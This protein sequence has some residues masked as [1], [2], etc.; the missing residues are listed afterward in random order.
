MKEKM[1]II[2]KKIYN[3]LTKFFPNVS[4]VDTALR[5]HLVLNEK[6]ILFLLFILFLLIFNLFLLLFM[7]PL[8]FFVLFMNPTILFQLILVLSTVL[9]TK[10]FQFQLN[11]LFS[12]KL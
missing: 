11:K 3:G 7:V 5:L 8:H 2:K 10:S 4:I 12:N 9:L 6:D 1:Y